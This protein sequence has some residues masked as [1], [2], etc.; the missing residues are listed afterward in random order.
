MSDLGCYGLEHHSG[1]NVAV[2]SSASSAVTYTSVYTDSEPD[3]VYWGADEELSDEGS[4]RVIVYE[5]DGL[6]MQLVAP[7]LP[8]YIHGL[9]EPHTPPVLHDEDEQDEHVF[10]AEEQ[11]LPPVVS[12]TAE[13]PGYVAGSDPEE[14][15]DDESEDG[16]VNYPMDE[17]DNGDDDDEA[18]VERLLAM[19][20]PPPSPLTSLSPPSARERLARLASAQALIDAVTAALPLPPLPPLPPPLY[21][22]EQIQL[23][24][25]KSEQNRIKT[26][27]KREATDN[28]GRFNVVKVSLCTYTLNW[29][30]R[31]EVYYECKEPFKSLK[32]LWIRSKSIAATWLEK[33][34]TPLIEPCGNILIDETCSKCNSGAGNSFVYDLTPKSFN[35]VQIIFNP[36][37]QPHYNI[38]LCQICESNSHYGYECLQQVPIVYEPEPCYNQSFGDNA[39]PHDS[40]GIDSL[41]DEFVGELILLKSIP[42]R[43]YEADCDP[44]EEIHLIEKLLND[45]SSPRPP[46]EFISKNSDAAIESFS[47]SPILNLDSTLQNIEDDVLLYYGGIPAC[48]DDDD[49]YNSTITP[50]LFTEEPVDSLSMGDEHLDTIPATK[51]DEVI[52]SSVED[53]VPILSESEGILE[54]MCDVHLVNNPTP[55]E[56]KDYFEIVINSNDD[57]SLS[58]DDSL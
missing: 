1:A 39:Y 36:P 13:S 56:A 48:C 10:L 16:P 5:Y 20:N 3:R 50:V 27:Q 14:Y 37:P 23:K 17:G 9:E 6:P 44:E 12:L 25:D 26:E 38:Y 58:D 24:R 11:P 35:E 31:V 46:E 51:S 40:P 21:I 22:W 34:V 2:M 8:D 47:P 29:R 53:L 57:I 7:P 32:C 30:E 55:L 4:P 33:V 49:D 45:N 15:E 19:P 52:K 43:I 41:L 54:T 42:P 18:E 28:S